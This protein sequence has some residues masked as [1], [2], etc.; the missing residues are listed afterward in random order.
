MEIQNVL[1]KEF[2]DICDWFVDNELS[3]RCQK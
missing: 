1:D 2:G 3:I